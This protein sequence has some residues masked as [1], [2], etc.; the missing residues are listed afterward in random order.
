MDRQWETMEKSWVPVPE[1]RI[2]IGP[3]GV[4]LGTGRSTSGGSSRPL[5]RSAD[6]LTA[7]SRHGTSVLLVA[8]DC[9]RTRARFGRVCPECW[10]QITRNRAQATDVTQGSGKTSLAT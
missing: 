7:S 1:F 6:V 3:L 10:N 4:F 9:G 8:G 2:L 5:L